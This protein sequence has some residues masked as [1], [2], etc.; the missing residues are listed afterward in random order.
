MAKENKKLIEDFC[1]FQK[2]NVRKI[3]FLNVPTPNYLNKNLI[4]QSEYENLISYI[5]E[6]F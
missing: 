6:C 1:K 2:K 5:G 4:H 3:V